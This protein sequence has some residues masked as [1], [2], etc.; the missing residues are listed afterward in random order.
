MTRSHPT[1]PGS[2]STGDATIAV[3]VWH[4]VARD[5]AGRPTGYFGF[6][7]GDQ[8]VKV[9][10]YDTDVR[11]R[12]PEDIAEDAFAAFN[13]HPA[14]AEGQAVA[15]QYRARRL[16][17]LSFPGNRPCCPRSCCP[18]RS[19]VWLS[20]DAETEGPVKADSWRERA[21]RA[22]AGLEMGR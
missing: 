21:R 11:D 15:R 13:D 20:L 16:R 12:H 19:V 6:T 17:S 8:M 18:R 3:S 14:D 7:L 10:T 1:P 4:N 2:G 9:F 22:L 5:S